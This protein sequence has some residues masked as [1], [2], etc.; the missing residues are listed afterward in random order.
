V[1]NAVDRQPQLR[2]AAVEELVAGH[3]GTCDAG[4]PTALGDRSSE[5]LAL[6][7]V[8]ERV[9][10]E[11][12][13]QRSG[14]GLVATDETS[15]RDRADHCED[16]GDRRRGCLLGRCDCLLDHDLGLGVRL[17]GGGVVDLVSIRIRG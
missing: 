6:G 17:L 12:L 10:C 7:G 11:N 2:G 16:L 14:Q 13:L 3:D 4:N 5:Q 8:D 1:R 9:R 15:T